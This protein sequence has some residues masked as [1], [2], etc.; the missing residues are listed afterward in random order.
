MRCAAGPSTPP[1]CA[2]AD[3]HADRARTAQRARPSPSF[4]GGR[5]RDATVPLRP[6]APGDRRLDDPL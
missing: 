1:S 5:E 4:R 3:H 2:S 6:P